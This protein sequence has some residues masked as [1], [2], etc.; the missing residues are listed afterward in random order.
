[1]EQPTANPSRF[2]P[3][4]GDG[5]MLVASESLV[6]QRLVKRDRFLRIRGLNFKV[7]YRI[8]WLPRYAETAAP[9]GQGMSALRDVQIT[10]RRCE[11]GVWNRDFMVPDTVCWSP[12]SAAPQPDDLSE[13]HQVG[14]CPPKY[15]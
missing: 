9:G 12:T 11:N 2:D 7:C 5:Q 14:Q 3:P 10:Q 4:V 1:M 13:Q 6:E 15:M 8:H